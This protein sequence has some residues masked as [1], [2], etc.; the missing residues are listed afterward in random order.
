MV[1]Y[2]NIANEHKE[3][4]ISKSG[5]WHK[6]IKGKES[7]VHRTTSSFLASSPGHCKAKDEPQFGLACAKLNKKTNKK[8]SITPVTKNKG[9]CSC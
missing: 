4:S 3:A 9:R 7:D 8:S 5:I 6:T 2:S 1:W